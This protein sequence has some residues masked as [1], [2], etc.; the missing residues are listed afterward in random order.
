[1]T[2][3]DDDRVFA[4]SAHLNPSAASHIFQERTS[5]MTFDD[6][7]RA[8]LGRAIYPGRGTTAGIT[9]TALGV[10]GEAGECAEKVK[11]LLRDHGGIIP[12]DAWKDALLRE[13]GDTLW[14]VAAMANELGMSLEAVAERNLQK[15]EG[16]RIS[17]TLQGSGDDR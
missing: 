8:A 12:N 4:V 1:V 5:T 6:Y 2:T 17:G 9:Y 10:A 13:L 7:Q 3:G 16:R 14:Y 15:I 11:K